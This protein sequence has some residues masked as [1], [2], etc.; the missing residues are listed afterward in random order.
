MKIVILIFLLA[1]SFYSC[2]ESNSD[3]INI[4]TFKC[5]NTNDC[6][7]NF[8]ENL[9]CLGA[10]CFEDICKT[11]NIDCGAGVCNYNIYSELPFCNCNEGVKL[12]QNKYITT[13]GFNFEINKCLEESF[14]EIDKDCTGVFELNDDNEFTFLS[15]CDGGR[16]IFKDLD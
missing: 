4:N 16:C 3:K 5:K 1:F 13:N 14:C 8:G 9:A 12:Y 7:E 15:T 11:K 2:E 6:L 10:K